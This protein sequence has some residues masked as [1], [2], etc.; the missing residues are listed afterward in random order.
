MNR[1]VAGVVAESGFRV[2]APVR[3]SAARQVRTG[4][5]RSDMER[6]PMLKQPPGSLRQG[7]G[8]PRECRDV[9]GRIS[10]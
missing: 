2:R 10:Q 7:A 8:T 3:R 5:A 9:H 4:G 6:L 1:F